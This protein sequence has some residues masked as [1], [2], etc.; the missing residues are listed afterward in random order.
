[1][2]RLRFF[3]L[4]SIVLLSGCLGRC[5]GDTPPE[6]PLAVTTPAEPT[7]APEPTPVQDPNALTRLD[8]LWN[9]GD[10]KGTEEAFRAL[11]EETAEDETPASVPL[12]LELQTQIARTLGLQGKFEDAHAL[13]DRVDKAIAEG[14]TEPERY[15]TARVRALLERGRVLNS[16]GAEKEEARALFEEAFAAAGAAQ[17]D[18]YAVDAAHMVAIVEQGTEEELAWNRKALALAESSADPK[19]QK[20]KGSLYNNLGWGEHDRGNFDAA[21]AWFDKQIVERTATG[22]EPA[23]RKAKWARGRCL[24]SLKRHED[25][26]AV[27]E[28]LLRDYPEAN[29]GFIYEELGELMLLMEQPQ[30]APEFFARAFELLKDGWLAK[31][32][33]E[34]LKRMATL[35]GVETGGK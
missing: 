4:T 1:M 5:G 8:E 21:L 24:R 22:K 35:G 17:K 25:A 30:R 29:D 32:E 13:L 16:S 6:A 19:A 7:P 15:A 23:L 26:L 31:A 9:F 14:R 2:P 34:R 11:L 20:W 27:H 28:A 12:R 18:G 33:P 10:P 3:A